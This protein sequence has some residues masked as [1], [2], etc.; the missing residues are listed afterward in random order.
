M[1]YLHN[2]P[3]STAAVS[4]AGV[5]D[6]V[7]ADVGAAVPI[8]PPTQSVEFPG[9]ISPPVASSTI[10]PVQKSNFSKWHGPWPTLQISEEQPAVVV[11]VV[12]VIVVGTNNSDPSGHAENSSDSVSSLVS[13][14]G[15]MSG[16]VSHNTGHCVFS[17][18]K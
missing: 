17:V 16:H 15:S 13:T 8:S 14:D 2:P 9:H 3:G 4:G 7:G 10:K 12:V 1:L 11:V 5:G 6:A 18:A